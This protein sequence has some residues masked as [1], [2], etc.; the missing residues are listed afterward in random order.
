MEHFAQVIEQIDYKI[1]TVK[2]DIKETELHLHKQLNAGV[3]E[4]YLSD[5]YAII[6]IETGRLDGLKEALR[7]LQSELLNYHLSQL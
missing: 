3:S 5:Y 2:F 4:E 7:I 6:D 1:A